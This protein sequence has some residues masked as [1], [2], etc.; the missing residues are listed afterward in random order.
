M[1]QADNNRLDAFEQW[2]LRRLCNIRWTDHVTNVEIRRRTSQEP[3]S[4]AVARRRRGL[5]GHVARLDRLCDTSRAL[6]AKIPRDWKRLK[7]RPGS[8]LVSTVEKNLSPLN[9]RIFV[10]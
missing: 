9:F 1:T 3:L 6:R 5:Y 7:G 4:S 8:T 2:C 10:A